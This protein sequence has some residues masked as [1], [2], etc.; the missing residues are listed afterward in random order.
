[1][2]R[3][4]N[5]PGGSH[6]GAHTPLRA[7]PAGKHREC[8][9]AVSGGYGVGVKASA[10]YVD[11]A[12][13][14]EPAPLPDYS[15]LVRRMRPPR[16]CRAG[17]LSA[18]VR[19]WVL[20]LE[21]GTAF[22]INDLPADLRGAAPRVLCDMTNEY[23]EVERIFKGLYWRG[24]PPRPH[25]PVLPEAHIAF[26]YAGPGAGFADAS[27][28]N[29]LGWTA[30]RPVKNWVAV[31]GRAPEAR[32]PSLRFVSRHNTLRR[33]LTWAEVTLI[34]GVRSAHLAEDFDN[35]DWAKFF[36]DDEPACDGEPEAPVA[37]DS[38]R[39]RAWADA[40]KSVLDGTA[41]NRLGRGA[42]L[43]PEAIRTAALAERRAPDGFLDRVDELTSQMPPLL[44]HDDPTQ[45]VRLYAA[46]TAS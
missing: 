11:P 2:G 34:E 7:G 6:V 40:V 44:R 15:A 24:P 31:V 37:V 36:F 8:N 17:S 1:M 42:L 39:A 38:W 3:R 14:P 33:T 22:Y 12:P 23:V 46:G 29:R 30:Q 45:R 35:N 13:L 43:R 20:A 25:G 41:I 21:E 27:A 4:S 9:D 5:T 32:S 10:L 19:E 16:R 28:V 18:R 26:A